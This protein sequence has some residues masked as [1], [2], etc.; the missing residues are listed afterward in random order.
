MNIEYL[1]T[2]LEGG[3]GTFSLP[4]ILRT[5]EKAGG[6]VHLSACEP[7]DGLGG[8]RLRDEGFT[9]T[10]LANRKRNK[11]VYLRAFIRQVRH[12]RP[13]VI[14][15][16]LSIASLVGQ[17]TGRLCGVP[18]VS[19]LNNANTKLYTKLFSRLTDLWI[20]DSPSVQNYLR[21]TLGVPPQRILVWPL[22]CA[23]TPHVI[24]HYWKGT[25]C[26]HLG[27]LGRL[28]E[29]KNYAALIR[30]VARF[31]K[32]APQ[33]RGALR[34]S[35]AGDGPLR[36][37]LQSLIDD[38]GL[39]DCI[40]LVGHQNDP[41]AFLLTLDAYIQP[42]LYEGMCLAAH[43]AMA[44]GLPV[45]AT[46]AGELAHSVIRDKTGFVIDQPV[47]SSVAAIL[48]DL[49]ANPARL[50]QYGRAG[51]DYVRTKF[52]IEN[53]NAAGFAVL[54]RIKALHTAP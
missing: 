23:T 2:S 10:L 26:L 13:D 25:G 30:A 12:S 18:V 41:D 46:P 43:E 37:S 16:S 36:S 8:V 33:R 32:N 45:I 4:G 47:E 9:F 3:G 54:E 28:N 38:L 44:M 14:W 48:D 24:S 50:E 5:I 1:V 17:I 27:S 51:R 29:Q 11:L 6:H 7:R 42:S 22:Y 40:M 52:S 19:W 20:A 35:L 31:L 53:F 49:F 21:E 34:V 39:N 15:T